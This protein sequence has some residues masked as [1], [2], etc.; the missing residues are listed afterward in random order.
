M[1]A[2]GFSNHRT[3]CPSREELAAFSAGMMASPHLEAVADHLCVCPR[4]ESTVGALA[5]GRDTIIS[6]LRR[7][8][9]KEPLLEEPECRQ[10]EI[11]AKAIRLD[12]ASAPS[13]LP[14]RPAADLADDP[15]VP[16]QLGLYELLERLGKGGMGVVY[17]AR[18]PNL[19]R[20]VALKR[21]LS[22]PHASSE[23]LAR[24][25]SEATDLARLRHPNIVQI[26]ETG[27]DENCPYFSM[28]FVDGG[29]LA[30]HLDGAPLPARRAAELVQTLARAIH[31]A[32]QQGIVHRDLKPAN[33]LLTADG[34]PK[35]TDFGLAKGLGP[36][37]GPTELG[38]ILGTP[39]YMAP[40]QAAGKND[41]IGPVTDVYGLGAIL[42]ELLTGRPPFR[43]TS[44][45]DTLHQVRC[46]EPVPPSRLQPKVFGKGHRR[47]KESKERAR[48]PF[49]PRDLETICLKCLQKEPHKRYASALALAE[50]IQ[51]CL[52]GEPILAR[53]VGHAERLWRWCRRNP[54]LAAASGLAAVFLVLA[55]GLSTIFAISQ[56]HSAGR[57]AHALAVK[58]QNRQKLVQAFKRSAR[59]TLAQGLS[60]CEQGDASR[61]VLWLAHSLEMATQAEDADLER[62]IRT[63]LAS[64][65]PQL[66]ALRACLVHGGDVV[67]VAFS[68]DG[69]TV[70]TG[71][72]DGHA[73]RW[74]TASGERVGTP[75]L[76][77]DLVNAVAFSPDGKIIAT[78]SGEFGTRGEARFWDA[79]TGNP[80]GF[81]L[82][83]EGPVH[84]MAFS[85]DGRTILTTSLNK[86][87]SK[88]EV[89]LWDLAMGTHRLVHQH[90]DVAPAAAWSADGGTFVIGMGNVAQIWCLKSGLFPSPQG[91]NPLFQRLGQP[92]KHE[93]RIRAVAF[94]PDGKIVLTGS[95]DKTAR[96]WE[97]TTGRPIGQPLYHHAEVSAVAFS[98]DGQSILTGCYDS[99]ARLWQTSTGKRLSAPLYHRGRVLA[100]AFGCN[101]TAIVTGADDKTARLWDVACVSKAFEPD[102]HAMRLESLTYKPMYRF[103]Q[104]EGSVRA[105]AFSP[106]GKTALTGS[107]DGRARL[108][109][110][111]TG[112][113][114]CQ[115]LAHKDVVFALSFSPDGK[116]VLTG[117]WDATACLWDASTGEKLHALNGH[118][119]LIHAVAF[120]PDGKIAVTASAD[121]RAQ[122]WDVAKGEPIGRPLRHQGDVT[123]VAF[124]PDGRA[125]LT[126]SFDNT[127][128]LWETASGNL[129][130]EFR[131]HKKT[132]KFVAFSPDGKRI[133]TGSLDYTA[134][135]WETA[136]G[137]PVGDPLIHQDKVW[138]GRFSPDGRLIVTA[139]WDGTARL[140]HAP[141]GEPAGR[142]LQH[143]GAVVAVT[144]SP[145]GK[146]LLTGSRDG[147]ARIWDVATGEPIGPSFQ[148]EGEVWAVGYSRDGKTVLTGSD[149]KTA[150][151][152]QLPTPLPLEAP[153]ERVV[154]WTQVVTGMELDPNGLTSAMDVQTWQHRCQ[155]LL[156]MSG[157]H[158]ISD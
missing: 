99:S 150:R 102:E 145:D 12:E 16:A 78:G 108:W 31:H 19:N 91:D 69:K 103:L 87:S 121:H 148:H 47:P 57:L 8:V 130:Y 120:S 152:W 133:L 86:T 98:P 43:G 67:A 20:L 37:A 158:V 88:G 122:L 89:R 107:W 147:T 45:T 144:F 138:V 84:A 116:S 50:E 113:P 5:D 83:H 123:A 60:L 3:L 32:H 149:D 76:H 96:L 90:R 105:A 24:F 142:A 111:A 80:I 74:D 26:Y 53:P 29:S 9:P 34:V 4:C 77:Q 79:A 18:Q 70:L 44:P 136:S 75:L 28:E 14:T 11:E 13:S 6:E 66:C 109:D 114:R 56:S 131:G 23:E 140:W 118:T 81:S 25:H 22:G 33:V 157:P 153:V 55:A 117:G 95:E 93:K 106:D 125:V 10:L 2:P 155:H 126:G 58:E 64:A 135:I 42:Y 71:S 30:R 115:P 7:A 101:G 21:I 51:R 15:P 154:L 38:A 112:K 124:S 92:L 41:E 110:V 17:K 73:Q 49:F 54:A 137:L 100:V 65:R 143:Q 139:S 132:V 40:E 1:E 39:S 156:E 104:H 46:Q 97:A 129:V 146:R 27:Q 59:I 36:K 72:K 61:G 35:I 82:R 141:T 68:P 94:S 52:R 134:R 119:G 85:P 48:L 63:N 128:R 62:I 151:L 127:A